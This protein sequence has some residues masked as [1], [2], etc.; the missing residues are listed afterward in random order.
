[1]VALGQLNCGLDTLLEIMGTR[2]GRLIPDGVTNALK[3][4]TQ[5][6]C[7][8]VGLCPTVIVM[9]SLPADLAE[10]GLIF[11]NGLSLVGQVY[12]FL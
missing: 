4:G 1:M 10:S 11:L 2:N 6:R 3:C 5:V 8:K 12:G 7:R 9:G